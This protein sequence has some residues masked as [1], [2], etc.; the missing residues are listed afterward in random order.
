MSHKLDKLKTYSTIPNSWMKDKRLNLR[1]RGL[2]CTIQ[3]LPD[4]WE[5]TVRGLKSILNE[6][7]EYSINRCIKEAVR[8]GYLSWEQKRDAEGNFSVNIVRVLD[9]YTLIEDDKD[10][11]FTDTR[12]SRNGDFQYNI[13]NNNNKRNNSNVATK[14]DDAS[15]QLA[16]RLYKW[17]LHNKPNRKISSNWKET[18]SKDISLLNRIDGRDYKSIAKIIDFSQQ[19]EFWKVNILSGAKLRKQFDRL[20]D[21]YSRTKKSKNGVLPLGS[22]WQ[23][24]LEN[25]VYT[26][27]HSDYKGA[28]KLPEANEWIMH[29]GSFKN[30]RKIRIK[31]GE[32]GQ[33]IGVEDV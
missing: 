19:H 10:S 11:K 26:P 12:N 18:W 29:D 13:I 1:T 14:V 24:T 28:Y 33:P 8:F 17:I 23:I 20:E 6:E 21:E 15:V 2:L 7:S 30:K 16:T 27:H 4:N 32:D 25:G 5:F 9:G 3:S 22:G 31:I